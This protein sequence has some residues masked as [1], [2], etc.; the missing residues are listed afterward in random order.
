MKKIILEKPTLVLGTGLSGSGKSTQLRAI[1]KNVYDTFII[2][3]DLMNDTFLLQR[4]MP[5]NGVEAYMLRGP[6]L[7]RNSEEYHDNVKFQSYQYML[8]L[9]RDNLRFG[10]HPLIE[11]NYTKE[12]SI[13]YLDSVVI[14]FFE[15]ID[16]R[17]K[18][19]HCHASEDTLR[20]RIAERGL[21]RDSE[22]LASWNDFI[23]TNPIIPKE[24]KRYDHIEV[25]TEL[26]MEE[27]VK[28]ILKYLQE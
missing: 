14:P 17:M 7:R 5:G 13:G 12:I 16:Y 10:K 11:G 28:I 19:V 8:E 25:D 3:K 27:N 21:E 9:A 18:I 20:R 1:E 15:S 4:N 2:D 26:P 24:L 23:S 22:K 6:P